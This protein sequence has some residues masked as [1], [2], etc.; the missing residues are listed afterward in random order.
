MA[1]VLLLDV[2]SLFAQV[3]PLT[4]P[5]VIAAALKVMPSLESAAARQDLSSSMVDEARAPLLPSVSYD[6][7]YYQAPGYS[8]VITNGGQSD[9]M[10]TL[11]Y[12]VFDGGRRMALMRAARFAAQASAQGVAA[13][14]QQIEFDAA[15]AYYKLLQT[16]HIEEE[17]DRSLGRL[18]QYLDIIGALRRRGRAIASDTL[19]IE[20][21]RDQAQ[22]AQLNAR[23]ERQH[24]SMVLGSMM[25]QFGRDD[26]AVADF[27]SLPPPPHGQLAHNP[28]M[29]AA[30]R[31]IQ[32][33][34]AAVT[35]AHAEAYPT[36]NL[37]L[38]SGFL[39]VNPRHTIDHN[40]GASYDGL[41][42]VPIFQGGLIRAH[43]D[44]AKAR[45]R[46]AQA[47]R[48]ELEFSLRQRLS[49]ASLRYR[50]AQEQLRAIDRSEPTANSAFGLYWTRFLGGGSAT[51]LEVLDAY[52]Q[53][54]QLRI[55]RAQQEFAL[56]QASAEGRLLVG[57]E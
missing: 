54:E 31:E 16:R 23:A 20:S 43:V 57:G 32:N 49:D 50:Q 46:A 4:L 22:I 38:T 33:A 7:E 9:T 18:D 48:H 21:A 47:S 3:K 37:N 41:I 39:G 12:V 27:T 14:R 1:L 52:N 24:A 15:I 42:S 25:G 40:L 10:L 34:E 13:A 11:N 2:S 35:A 56:R 28:Q 29:I 30:E 17:Q 44:E 8:T 45:L 36:F 26:L 55:M 53:A 19:K 6:T 5:E 51:L